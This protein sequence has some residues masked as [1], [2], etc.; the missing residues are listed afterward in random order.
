MH[1]QLTAALQARKNK[2]ISLGELE[3]MFDGN[4]SYEEF[5]ER[6]RALEEAG[7]LQP[8]KKHGFTPGA[9]RLAN[10]YR[11]LKPALSRSAAVEIEKYQFIIDHRISLEDYY[12]LPIAEWEKDLPF[13]RT[14]N[15]YLQENGLTGGEATAPEWSYRLAGDEKW[16]ENGHGKTVLKRLG[17][18]NELKIVSRP[19]PLM[20]AL[21]PGAWSRPLCRILIIEN[22]SPFYALLEALPGSDWLA[23][24]YGAGWKIT[25]R[26]SVV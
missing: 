4:T 25:D 8:V 5:A 3:K 12:S 20:L 11:I 23:I 21:N 2:T 16:I 6:V 14:V 18:W 7:I 13:I 15:A 9:R 19:E 22:K 10:T 24:V 26:K 1:D 17:L